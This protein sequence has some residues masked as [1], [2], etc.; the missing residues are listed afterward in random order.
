MVMHEQKLERILELLERRPYWQSKALVQELGAS[1]S[2][3]QRCL[4]ELHRAGLAE[5]IHGGVRRRSHPRGDPIS[6]DERMGKD[7]EAKESMCRLA[8]SMVPETGFVYLDAGTTILPLAQKLD[9][10]R[11]GKAQFVTNDLAI[12]R[13]LAR[14]G[15]R[16]ILL[17]GSVHSVTQTISGPEAQRQIAG[18]SFEVCFLSA[19]GV[20]PEAGVSC[21]VAEE[22][23]LK[24]EALDRSRRR[25]LL[26][27]YS[28]WGKRLG[29][30]ICQL[31]ELHHL[32][33]D[34]LPSPARRL[35]AES[36]LKIHV[37][38]SGGKK[39]ARRRK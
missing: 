26:A 23:I 15:I 21:A 7:M 38:N 16:H 36:G 22:A 1:Q 37:P 19:D 11:N 14:R 12:A 29:A 5:R 10:S 28:K 6:V 20:S 2:T 31:A 8:A 9:A 24:R 25:V 30:L 32:V 34:K 27:A 13:A 17:G 33:C 3:V 18:Y 4:D 35:C 39:V